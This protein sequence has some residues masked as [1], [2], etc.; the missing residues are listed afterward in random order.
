MIVN[1]REKVQMQSLYIRA[2]VENDSLGEIKAALMQLMNNRLKG[3]V[4]GKSTLQTA[5]GMIARFVVRRELSN[6]SL[7]Q[8]TRYLLTL[9][10]CGAVASNEVQRFDGGLEPVECG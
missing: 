4:S 1:D 3:E 7:R 6:E 9:F 2:S 10:P 5:F 8:I